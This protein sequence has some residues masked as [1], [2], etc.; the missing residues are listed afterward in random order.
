MLA[1][2]R[3]LQGRGHVSRFLRVSGGAISPPFSKKAYSA[4]SI[5]SCSSRAHWQLVQT[6]FRNG[7]L[8]FGTRSIILNPNE[9]IPQE[10]EGEVDEALDEEEDDDFGRYKKSDDEQPNENRVICE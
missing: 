10:D 3:W 2:M 8:P 1:K 6:P 9:P 5:C 7:N 4:A